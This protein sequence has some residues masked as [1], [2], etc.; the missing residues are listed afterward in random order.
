MP[1]HRFDSH[2]AL[3]TG[4]A[5]RIGAAIVRHLH[6]AGYRVL[7]HH[8]RSQ[9]EAELL[10]A[11]L[12]RQVPN[13]AAT[14]SA[15]LTDTGALETLAEYAASYWQRFD[16]LVNN[17][18]SFYPTPLD[19][20]NEQQWHDLIGTNL[21][22]PLWLTKALAQPLRQQQGA[23]VNIVDVHAE[24]G[25]Q[26]YSIYS[27][28]KAGLGLL[29]QQLA[30]EL[31]P[32]VRVNGIAPGPILPPEGAA[33]RSIEVQRKVLDQTLLKRYGTPKDIAEA[34]LFLAKQRFTTGQILAV[35]GGK[36]VY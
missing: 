17:A 30:K 3:V 31:A 32:E 33:E 9:A 25:L 14:L 8:H 35:D 13:S 22:A 34:V 10:A 28:A 21:K 20:I 5:R 29:T 27:A 6:N 4:G 2:V 11:E 19:T 15:D 23:I 7:I 18:S 26:D 16:L 1:S 36:S 24:H 12:N